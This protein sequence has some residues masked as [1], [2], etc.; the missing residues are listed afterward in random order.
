MKP[1]RRLA[2]SIGRGPVGSLLH[3]LA[4]LTG[5]DRLAVLTYH[6]IAASPSAASEMSPGLLSAL[7]ADFAD[8]LAHARRRF[9]LIEL[10]DM[11]DLRQGGRTRAR[12]PLVLITFDDA[13]R[14]FL[15]VAW[16][17]IQRARVPVTVF[18]AT[19]MLEAGQP[20]WWDQLM[21]TLRMTE[22]D[23]VP[24]DGAP[25]SL[26]TDPD[27][28]AAYRVIHDALQDLDTAESE[29]VVTDLGAR[30][31]VSDGPHEALG[32]DEITELARAG[33]SI[34]GHSHRHHRLDRMSPGALADDLDTCRRLLTEHLG[35]PPRAFA[36]P[37]GYHSQ[38]TADAV[39]AAG[40]ELAFTTRRG[41]IDPRRPDWYRLPRI[42]VG[43]NSNARL[44]GLQTL[45]LPRS[46]RPPGGNESGPSTD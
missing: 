21:H 17:M 29:R 2:L 31:D 26:R 42:N 37:T 25:L 24:W 32:W 19:A 10:D 9:T 13:Y 6:R 28:L 36:Y 3:R 40:F 7:V 27:R 46:A 45:L 16:P 23:Q 8:H 22:A 39:A 11:L 33:V 15:D 30:L 44:I 18:V 12:R 38:A 41:V 4:P 1:M 35:S 5:R 34:G 14:D 43:H 20:F